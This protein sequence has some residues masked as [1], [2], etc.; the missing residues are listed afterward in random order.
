[1]KS[2]ITNRFSNYVRLDCCGEKTCQILIEVGL[3][4]TIPLVSSKKNLPGLFS[5]FHPVHRETNHCPFVC[6]GYLPQSRIRSAVQDVSFYDLLDILS[7]NLQNHKKVHTL[8]L[9]F[10]NFN[11]KFRIITEFI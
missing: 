4:F 6:Y 8:K 7:Y 2:E 11:K 10:D 5:S 9:I 3:C 1:M